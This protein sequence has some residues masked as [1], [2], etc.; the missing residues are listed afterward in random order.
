M[1]G[2]TACSCPA[3]PASEG[4]L[5]SSWHLTEPPSTDQGIPRPPLTRSRTAL[6]SPEPQPQPHPTLSPAKSEA[7]GSSP[8]QAP[9]WGVGK[10]LERR[11]LGAQE[12]GEDGGSA[13]TQRVAHHNQAVVF[14]SAALGTK[15]TLRA[16]PHCLPSCLPS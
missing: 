15:T 6:P 16:L 3:L 14:G 10:A 9:W 8:Q 12:E 11:V 13:C 5:G 2:W 4:D 7:L 1:P